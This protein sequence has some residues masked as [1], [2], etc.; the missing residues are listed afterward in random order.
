MLINSRCIK[1]SLRL[2]GDSFHFVTFYFRIFYVKVHIG[3]TVPRYSSARKMY[4]GN[5]YFHD[6]MDR[7]SKAKAAPPRESQ[8]VAV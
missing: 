2:V 6:R 3:D 8:L 1:Y 7:G 4:S 5:G